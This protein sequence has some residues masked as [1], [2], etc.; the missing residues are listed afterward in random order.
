MHN[1]EFI[2]VPYYYNT[3][4]RLYFLTFPHPIYFHNIS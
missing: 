2:K 1:I 4:Y 3:L